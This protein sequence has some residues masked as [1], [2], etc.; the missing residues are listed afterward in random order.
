M[1]SLRAYQLGTWQKQEVNMHKAI[2][3][4]PAQESTNRK[5]H[6]RVQQWAEGTV[7]MLTDLA[8]WKLKLPAGPR[9]QCTTGTSAPDTHSLLLMT[10]CTP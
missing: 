3:Q 7:P 4:V 6:Q 2:C 8:G 1:P 10:S 5:H 9:Q